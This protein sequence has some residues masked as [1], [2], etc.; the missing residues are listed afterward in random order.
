[1]APSAIVVALTP[2]DVMEAIQIAGI[3]SLGS[4]AFISLIYGEL[5]LLR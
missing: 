3:V 2:S 1:M 5:R 4:F